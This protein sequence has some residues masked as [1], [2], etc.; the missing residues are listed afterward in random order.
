MKK[1][2]IIY[3]YGYK[4]DP[5]HVRHTKDEVLTKREILKL[6]RSFRAKKS[7]FY[8]IEAL[9]GEKVPLL[10][11]EKVNNFANKIIKLFQR[12]KTIDEI[13]TANIKR[14][15]FKNRYFWAILII[16]P[17]LAALITYFI[18]QFLNHK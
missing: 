18:T 8:S 4:N 14:D 5:L 16:S 17:F 11:I 1:Y 2:R 10:P 13:Q 6:K 9:D 15:F 7:F 12:K 3:T